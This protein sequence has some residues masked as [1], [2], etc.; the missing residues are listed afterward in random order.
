MKFIIDAQ[1]PRKL[2]YFLSEKGYDCIHTLDLPNG[3]KTQ[4]SEI[5]GISIEQERIVIS[6]DSDFYNSYLQ[7]VE[8]FKLIY[9]T[10]GNVSTK[11]LIDIFEKNHEKIFEEIEFNSV[12]EVTS[13]SIIT[14]L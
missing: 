14:I 4:D 8:P 3:N 13:S 7:K 2:S 5:N 9:L 6:K 11:K 10:I 12:V 1:L